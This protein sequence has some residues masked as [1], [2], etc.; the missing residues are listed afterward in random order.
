[1]FSANTANPEP[2]RNGLIQD[3][4]RNVNAGESLVKSLTDALTAIIFDQGNTESADIHEA[5]PL[6]SESEMFITERQPD[7]LE[8]DDR[9]EG[10]WQGVDQ[11]LVT[12]HLTPITNPLN[13]WIV[14]MKG[15]FMKA[16]CN[17]HYKVLIFL[18]DH[19]LHCALKQ[20]G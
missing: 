5:Y 4:N 10:D 8:V 2:C 1:M 3:K 9:P 17:M 6:N 13:R 19:M 18:Y 16:K 20:N 11:I 15:T 14:T 12:V 7:V